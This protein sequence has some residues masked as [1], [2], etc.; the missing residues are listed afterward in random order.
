MAPTTSGE[1]LGGSLPPE[2]A[3]GAARSVVT[4][5]RFAKYLTRVP[6]R[7]KTVDLVADVLRE[8][9]LDGALNPSE[10]LREMEI[11]QE[12]SVSRTPVREALTRLSS[13]GLAVVVANQGAMVAPMTIEDILEVYTVRENL[14]GLAARLAAKKRSREHL[15]HLEEALERMRH[16]VA[17]NRVLDLVH[18]NLAFHRA[19]RD[20]SENR[21]LSRFLGQVEHGVRRFGATTLG[22]PGRAQETLEEH[23]RILE[24]ITVGDAERAK[25]FAIDHMR[26][27]REL[28]ISMLLDR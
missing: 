7:G 22:L 26:R 15:E 16:A 27:A 14:E 25:K 3:S 21:L 10:W 5:S 12:L 23:D 28:R 1:G 2:A 13:E 20:S 4:E 18:L 8:A 11:A 24:A 17:D 9:I 19:I 6:E